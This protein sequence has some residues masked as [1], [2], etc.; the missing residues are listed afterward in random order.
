MIENFMAITKVP[1]FLELSAKVKAVWLF[2]NKTLVLGIF[3]PRNSAAKGLTQP[4][5]TLYWYSCITEWLMG[6]KDPRHLCS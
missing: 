1:R 3:Y 5:R 2:L 6:T 4:Y